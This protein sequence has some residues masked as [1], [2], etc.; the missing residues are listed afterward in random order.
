MS[1]VFSNPLIGFYP[2]N[3]IS[4]SV[5]LNVETLQQAYSKGIFPWPQ[6][7][8][9]IFWICPE[10]RGVIPTSTFYINGN[11]L[12]FLRKSGYLL[13]IN[14]DFSNIVRQCRIVNRPGQHSSWITDEIEAVYGELF[15]LGKAYC[16]GCYDNENLVG[17]IYGVNSYGCF[18]VESSFH[19][20]SNASKACLLTLRNL[21]LKNGIKY[22]DVQI[23]TN[24]SR[25]SNGQFIDKKEFLESLNTRGAIPMGLNRNIINEIEFYLNF[26]K[27]K[28]NF[29]I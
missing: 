17:G 14:E 9:K 2:N 11:S 28:N 4:E 23:L 10:N 24:F 12:K 16:L 22:I 25:E 21:L 3:I 26:L 13:R 18:S 6:P 27:E 29:Q 5:P 7:D 20:K 19:I 1:D 15:S 8:G